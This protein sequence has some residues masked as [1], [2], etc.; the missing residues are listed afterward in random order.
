MKNLFTILFLLFAMGAHAQNEGLVLRSE[1][2]CNVGDLIDEEMVV[3]G[4]SQGMAIYGD[5]AFL[6]HD[7]GQCVII[8]L[9]ERY[10]ISSYVME[11][12]VGHCNNA[13]FGREKVSKDSPFPLLYVSECRG[14]RACYVND[15]RLDGS[16]LVQ[17]IFYDGEDIVGP[18]DWL[19][20]AKRGHI[21]LYCTVGG[22]RTLKRFRLPRLADND[23]NGEVHLAAKD[24]QREI[25]LGEIAIPQGSF[26]WGRRVYLPEGVPS[27]DRRLHVV[28]LRSGRK[29]GVA[30]LNGIEYEPEGIATM[31]GELYISFHTPRSPRDNRIYRVEIEGVSH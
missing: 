17:K 22:E 2:W 24:V 25:V 29:L 8:N 12:N 30:D 31:G 14:E 4:S 13:S 9:R 5:V 20:D 10:F 11:G 27:R 18:A 26:V 1:E 3:S 19:V 7:K 28:D 15:V 23:S 6:M 21:Y 16:R